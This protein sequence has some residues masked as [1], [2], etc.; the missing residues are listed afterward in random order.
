A[1]HY[2]Q[3]ALLTR[4]GRRLWPKNQQRTRAISGYRPSAACRTCS[5]CAYHSEGQEGPKLALE[6][7]EWPKVIGYGLWTLDFGLWTA[8]PLYRAMDIRHSGAK[9]FDIELWP[10]AELRFLRA[11]ANWR[12][13]AVYV[14]L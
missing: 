13:A 12:C 1:H 2:P 9:R 11:R 3:L 10:L 4:P 8:T 14:A 6:R 5:V 7:S